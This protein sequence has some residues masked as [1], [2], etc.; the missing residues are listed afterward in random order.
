M[1][2]LGQALGSFVI[3]VVAARLLGL[4][5][6]AYFALL[7]GLVILASAV[8]AGAI[9]DALTVLDR[10]DVGLRSALQWWSVAPTVPAAAV[11]AV[12]V[13]ATTGVGPSA[14]A[15]FGVAAVVYVV[16]EM[17]RRLLM[18]NLRFWSVVLADGMALAVSLGVVV[19]AER[20][21]GA[22]LATFFAAVAAGQVAGLVTIA[23]VL[24][25][26]ER[27]LAPM[28]GGRRA[29]VWAYGRWRAAQQALRPAT[30]TVVRVLAIG[31]AGA[32][33]TGRLEAARVIVAPAIHLIGGASHFLVAD[34]ARDRS[35]PWAEVLRRTDR[36]VALLCA[37][38]VVLAGV[39]VAVASSLGG[40]LLGDEVGLAVP[41][42]LAWSS[43]A[44]ATSLST[45]YGAVAAVVRDQRGLAGIRLAESAATVCLV[46]L[47]FRA[48]AGI[49][50][51]PWV[52]AAV[53]LVAA[54][55]VRRSLRGAVT[56]GVAASPALG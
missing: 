5:G 24:P 53:T 32:T 49:V 54:G 42:L 6:L 38:V 30:L 45:P 31:V 2:Q 8:V 41:A 3:Q 18:A 11:A 48:G 28:L 33:A 29:E 26:E 21:T 36:R 10:S 1:V 12:V 16:E 20:G 35:R 34:T 46:A 17:G 44:V 51:A 15:W 47:V 55:A 14:A 50:W 13:A 40:A 22:V 19:V 23:V 43:Y 52:M 9:G 27:W 4:E 39:T 25:T 7:H 56:P 37:G